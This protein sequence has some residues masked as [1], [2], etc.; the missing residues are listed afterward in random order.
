MDGTWKHQLLQEFRGNP[1]EFWCFR[2]DFGHPS[3]S[4]PDHGTFLCLPMHVCR[5]LSISLA[6]FLVVSHEVGNLPSVWVFEWIYYSWEDE[7]LPHLYS[8]LFEKWITN[9]RFGS[10]G[11]HGALLHFFLLQGFNRLCP[12]CFAFKSSFRWA[13]MGRGSLETLSNDWLVTLDHSTWIW[14]I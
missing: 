10:L 3:R 7:R 8:P 14:K 12:W 5:D 6:D 4:Q 13:R 11:S 9:H 2:G 1:M